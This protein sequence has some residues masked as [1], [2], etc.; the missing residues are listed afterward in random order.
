MDDR[1]I[2]IYQSMETWFAF[3]TALF[4]GFSLFLVRK[5]YILA[6]E[7]TSQ[8][9][10]KSKID[11]D[12]KYAKLIIET[13]AEFGLLLKYILDYRHNLENIKEKE[14]IKKEE[15]RFPDSKRKADIHL[16]F[17][18]PLFRKEIKE[19]EIN[20]YFSKIQTYSRI[21]DDELLTDFITS[22][23]FSIKLIFDEFKDNLMKTKIEMLE[24]LKKSTVPNNT[25]MYHLS[26]TLPKGIDDDNSHIIQQYMGI[27]ASL[28]KHLDH[29]LVSAFQ[30]KL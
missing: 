29:F 5:G 30:K 15:N 27:Y 13:M 12:D 23:L 3:L 4:S 22:Y 25:K 11:S 20:S 21:I 17:I 8:H 26:Q 14:R 24:E 2:G 19:Q 9:K 10:E 18:L 28:N 16:R 6:K 1:W 7:Y